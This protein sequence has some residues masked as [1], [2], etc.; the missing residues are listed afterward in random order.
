MRED[1]VDGGESRRDARL[2]MISDLARLGNR[3]ALVTYNPELYEDVDPSFIPQ[4]IESGVDPNDIIEVETMTNQPVQPNFMRDIF[5]Q[6]GDTL[7]F[8]PYSA[9]NW[10]NLRR[11]VPPHLDMAP[12]PVGHGGETVIGN[13]FAFTAAKNDVADMFNF[14]IRKK[15]GKII[16]S[17]VAA[18]GEML[19]QQGIKYFS[20]PFIA[21][22]G[23]WSVYG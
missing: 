19:S 6:L 2:T 18:T 14:L 17:F 7:Y 9:T 8:N 20:L 23:W 3:I 11:W 4:A 15:A 1:V 21:F 12:H 22:T 5:N 16:E 10:V 13:R